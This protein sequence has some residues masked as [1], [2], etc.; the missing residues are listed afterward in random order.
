M[1]RAL[2]DVMQVHCFGCGSLNPHGLRIKSYQAGEDVVCFWKGQPHH[3]GGFR[4]ALNGGII[5]SIVDCH[6]M[7][8]AYAA[9]CRAEGVE[10][11]A[12]PNYV[13][14]TAALKVNFVKPVPLAHPVELRARVAE[15]SGRK[16]IVRCSVRSAG[17]ECAN[18]EAIGVRVPL[19]AGQA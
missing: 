5:A 12:T 2:Q 11:S 8:T 10:I 17:I 6:A 19:P 4:D 13:F 3:S 18:A 15:L 1:E 16:A 7:W 9:A 14:V